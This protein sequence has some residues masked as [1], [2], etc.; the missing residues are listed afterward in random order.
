[1]L[2]TQRTTAENI[3]FITLVAFLDADLQDRYQEKQAFFTPFNQLDQIR[4][5]V[6]AYWEGQAVGCG[7]LRAY[8]PECAE[9]KRMFVHHTHRNK[10]IAPRILHE[11][12]QWATELDY[13]ACILET[14]DKQP[15]AVRLYQKTGYERI[16]NY[17]PYTHVENSICMKKNILP[18]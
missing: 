1:M 2:T 16:S 4:H 3:D 18:A 13:S 5:V 12:E 9:I 11:L 6:V 15:E 14:G 8:D 7:A 17:E 10:G